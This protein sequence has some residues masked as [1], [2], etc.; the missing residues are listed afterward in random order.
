MSSSSAVLERSLVLEWGCALVAFSPTAVLLLSM[1]LRKPHLLIV[2]V[3]SAFAYLTFAVLGATVW[4]SGKNFGSPLL[5]IV[6]A[7]LF[8]AVGRVQYLK[9]Y[10]RVESSIW[11]SIAQEAMLRASR[12]A[13]RKPRAPAS[14]VG[15]SPIPS[16]AAT[17]TASPTDMTL[18]LNDAACGLSAGAG[19]AAMHSLLL[20]GSLL[21][22]DGGGYSTLIQPSCPAIPSLIQSA[23]ICAL[24]SVLDIIMMATAFVAVPTRGRVDLSLVITSAILHFLASFSTLTNSLNLNMSGCVV[25]LPCLFAVVAGSVAIFYI[26]ISP[27]INI[28]K[29]GLETSTGTSQQHSSG[30]FRSNS[31]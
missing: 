2:T 9:V 20:Y 18:E 12:E 13:A 1:S 7:V 15:E 28:K 23:V 6:P 19:Y 10:R 30:V 5:A 26:K 27:R 16:Q 24:F 22:S 14:G 25:A 17:P 3:T 29:Q 31:Q 8:Q 21:A 11:A 4:I